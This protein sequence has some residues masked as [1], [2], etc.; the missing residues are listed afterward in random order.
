MPNTSH[1]LPEGL[2]L[3]PSV[4]QLPAQGGYLAREGPAT[5]YTAD[6]NANVYALGEPVPTQAAMKTL[7]VQRHRGGVWNVPRSTGTTAVSFL[8]PNKLTEAHMANVM[9]NLPMPKYSGNLDDLDEFE[10]T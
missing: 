5:P 7:Y 8:L 10:Q 4:V 2:E 1:A 6:P 9:A 3:G